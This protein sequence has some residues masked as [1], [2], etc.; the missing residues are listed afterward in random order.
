MLF[1]LTQQKKS[2]KKNFVLFV[3]ILGLLVSPVVSL[4]QSTPSRAETNYNGLNPNDKYW[5][6][7]YASVLGDC[8]ATAMRNHTD[9]EKL[10]GNNL[11]NGGG[12]YISTY[13][14]FIAG[15]PPRT[16]GCN[17]GSNEFA[18]AAMQR[19]GINGVDLLC[20]MGY[21]REGGAGCFSSDKP[22]A[23]E[24]TNNRKQKFFNALKKLTKYDHAVAE[25]DPVVQYTKWHSIVVNGC[26]T[27]KLMSKDEFDKSNTRSRLSFDAVD[28]NKVVKKYYS[29]KS[30]DNDNYFAYPYDREIYTDTVNNSI[31]CFDA[32]KKVNRSAQGYLDAML[33]EG[34][35]KFC[36]EKKFSGKDLEACKQGYSSQNKNICNSKSG[37]EKAACE[38]GLNAEKTNIN[39]E[40]K[41]EN[42][43]DDEN[44]GTT[45][46]VEGVGYII[47]PLM[48]YMGKLM[49]GAFNFIGDNFLQVQPKITAD[50]N[51]KTAWDSFRN[52]ANGL[53]VIAFIII[54]YSQIT[55][56]GISNYGIKKML[57]RLIVIALL[58][59][60]SIYLCQIAVD[61]SNI[62]GKNLHG[63]FSNGI[64]IGGGVNSIESGGQISAF[65]TAASVATVLALAGAALFAALALLGIALPMGLMAVLFIT[66]ILI[67]RQALI[68]LLIA[69]SPVAFAAYLL[70]NT[71]KL[72][73][74]WKSLFFSLLVLYPIIGV[75]YGA[76]G[77]AAFIIQSSLEKDFGDIVALVVR[78][79]PLFATLPLLKSALNATGRFGA[80][81]SG[82]GGKLDNW[83][84]NRGE[85]SRLGRLGQHIKQQHKIKDEQIKAG[86]YRG[87]GGFFN[88]RNIRSAASRGF[89]RAA[90]HLPS[91]R[92][93]A[94]RSTAI[95]QSI[96]R[97][98]EE[99][100]V[101]QS[102]AGLVQ[103]V[104]ES[105]KLAN[106][107]RALIEANRD[108]DTIKAR[109][110][111]QLLADKTG[112]PGKQAL[113][114]V[115]R[116]IGKQDQDFQLIGT[117]EKFAVQGAV[118]QNVMEAV[119]QEAGM[120]KG[121]KDNDFTMDAWI[122]D[123]ANN[124]PLHEFTEDSKLMQELS[125]K[126]SPEQVL[127][128]ISSNQTSHFITEDTAKGALYA[129]DLA[130]ARSADK[131]KRLQKIIQKNED[132][133]IESIDK[134]IKSAQ[135]QGAKNNRKN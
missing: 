82:I 42:K 121:L 126:L 39:P 70:P 38:A 76:S 29:L 83:A 132:K 92:N 44:N 21:T 18:K 30:K 12:G 35:E 125:S 107:Q 17:N 6:H 62:L 134:V 7:E 90:S 50:S 120:A 127:G 3:V 106:I 40:S 58:V 111:T 119:K 87:R 116:A 9:E 105:H 34:A 73:Q 24:N 65:Q 98:E 84:R 86:T 43:K 117:N 4:L 32:A 14:T 46:N 133:R 31:G 135:A 45:C 122:Y 123:N 61:V 57:P 52:I 72:F 49:D 129:P 2:L 97:R 128:Q 63:F 36:S 20:N 96:V 37:N 124:L 27:G 26:T 101:E 115:I 41:S 131:I 33:K 109:A 112:K 91:A 80:A 89:N 71:E 77:L 85:N 108:G 10:K 54:I 100:M 81:V 93:F 74:K 78:T 103:G 79:A 130:K 47:C 94:N 75:L 15:D 1:S 22:F 13:S 59:N 51:L 60:I 55:N 16:L 8:F 104:P 99:E 53:F 48:L 67:G 88:P 19:F 25:K 5:F 69:I 95:G 66:L 110:A 68:V 118:N 28:G 64:P 102:M 114:Q 113:N 11:F 56:L 23:Q